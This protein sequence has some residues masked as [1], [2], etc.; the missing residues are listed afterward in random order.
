MYQV[1]YGSLADNKV[2]FQGERYKYLQQFIFDITG[3]VVTPP[4]V[5][6]PRRSDADDDE[7]KFANAKYYEETY[8]YDDDYYSATAE[9]RTLC[10]ICWVCIAIVLVLV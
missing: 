9:P 1:F 2:L 10:Y 8:Y 5:P 3:D 6:S 4:P 7:V